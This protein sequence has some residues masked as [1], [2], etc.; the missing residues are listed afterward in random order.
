MSWGRIF[1]PY[2]PGEAPQRLIPSL[3]NVF[4]GEVLP[5]GVNAS[6]YRDLIHVED[7]A[8]AVLACTQSK[9]VGS[10][11]IC[12][13]KP[14]QISSIVDAVA[15]I[16]KCDPGIILRL[17]PKNLENNKFL[18][19]DNKKL[20]SLGWKQEIVLEQGLLNYQS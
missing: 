19:G 11:N 4:K 17:A 14:V 7:A 6:S 1:F 2:G 8:R 13:G 5:F 10:I 15:K 16:N 9:F 20:E 3:F 12:S 18:V